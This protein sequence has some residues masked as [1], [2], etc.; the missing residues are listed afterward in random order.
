MMVGFKLAPASSSFLSVDHTCSRLIVLL[1][2]VQIMRS[3]DGPNY[4]SKR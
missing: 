1:P 3:H 2:V 4:T